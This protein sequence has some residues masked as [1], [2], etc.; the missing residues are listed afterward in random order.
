MGLSPDGKSLTMDV[1]KYA[2]ALG[3]MKDFQSY[4]SNVSFADQAATDL[5]TTNK[6]AFMV[7]GPFADPSFE[8]AKKEKGLEYDYI[9]VPGSANTGALRRFVRG[10][11]HDRFSRTGY[12]SAPLS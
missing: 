2:D 5:F 11:R 3:F 12:S 10:P 1:S 6:M 4:S 8:Q 7:T 9:L